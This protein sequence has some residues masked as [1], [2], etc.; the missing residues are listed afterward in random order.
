MLQADIES[1]YPWRP[2][3][4]EHRCGTCSEIGASHRED[5]R[6]HGYSFRLATALT[7][8]GIAEACQ[9]FLNA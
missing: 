1:L 3:D 5:N 8:P 2:R 4:R 7:V 9:N 6:A